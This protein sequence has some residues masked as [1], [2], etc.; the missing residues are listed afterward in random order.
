MAQLSELIFKS[1]FVSSI[2][3]AH[4]DDEDVGKKLFNAITVFIELDP[5]AIN[6]KLYLNLIQE[7]IKRTCS[8][9]LNKK[10]SKTAELDRYIR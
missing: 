4:S 3:S 10:L 1:S 2:Q 8:L 5:T 7:S 9:V 6:F